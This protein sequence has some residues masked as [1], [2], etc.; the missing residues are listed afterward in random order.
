[1]TTLQDQPQVRSATATRATQAG[2][3]AGQLQSEQQQPRDARH[4]ADGEQGS[5]RREQ[6]GQQEETFTISMDDWFKA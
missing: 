6:G 5:E 3:T 2:D 1:M 4:A